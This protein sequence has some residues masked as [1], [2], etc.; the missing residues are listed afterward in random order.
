MQTKVTWNKAYPA[1]WN[2]ICP[3]CNRG[4]EK[5]WNIRKYLSKYYHP[6]CATYVAS[7][8]IKAAREKMRA[9]NETL[10]ITPNSK[11]SKNLLE[12]WDKS[13]L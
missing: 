8:P 13:L 3:H 9:D 12:M 11:P 2:G 6:Q 10:R 1:K 4:Y 5:G 7:E